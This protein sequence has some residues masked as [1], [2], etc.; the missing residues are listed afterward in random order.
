[1][2]KRELNKARKRAEIVDIA[3]RSFFERGYAATSMSAIAEELGGSK[4]TLWAH[5][6]SKEEL[7]AAVIDKEVESFSQDIDEVL[8]SQTYSVPALRR[9]CLRFLECL[10]RENSISL[11]NLILGEGGRFPEIREMFYSRGPA[12]IRKCVNDFFATRVPADQAEKLARVTL[13]AISG[14][15]SD[16]LLRPNKPTSTECEAYIASM[17]DMITCSIPDAP[18]PPD[19][20]PAP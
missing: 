13:A 20:Q 11:F 6:G 19:D 15:R 4:A 1:M 8:T 10:M 2:G 18:P 16:I 12:K 5:F 9:A 3:T 17:V 7:F 14:Y